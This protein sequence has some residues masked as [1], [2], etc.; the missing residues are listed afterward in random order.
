MFKAFQLGMT[1]VEEV[2]RRASLRHEPIQDGSCQE[3][4]RYL[5]RSEARMVSRI[6]KVD[7]CIEYGALSR[8]VVTREEALL[9]TERQSSSTSNG[10]SIG[11]HQ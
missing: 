1:F 5:Y 10:F 2:L 11:L 7:S 4:R 8:V 3:R 9:E 6:L